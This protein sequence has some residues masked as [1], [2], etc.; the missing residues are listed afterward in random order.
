MFQKSR[1]RRKIKRLM[2]IIH[3]CDYK[4]QVECVDI[5]HNVFNSCGS[6]DAVE[7][8]LNNALETFKKRGL[9]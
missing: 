4:T 8:F 6:Y 2:R 1:I 3:R 7:S 9:A 5:I